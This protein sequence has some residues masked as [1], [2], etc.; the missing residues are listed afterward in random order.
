MALVP[1]KITAL[2][3]SDADGTD[4]KNIVS[5]AVVIIYD[6]DGNAVTLYDDA[7]GTNP[8][9]S[10]TTDSS[11]QVV[12]WLTQ[13]EYE[14]EVNGSTRRSITVSGPSPSNLDT[15]ANL[16]LLNPT[17]DGQIFICRERGNA[18]YVLQSSGYTALDGDVTFANGRIAA[19]QNDDGDPVKMGAAA[20]GSTDD[21][22]IINQC[23][24]RFGFANI[25]SNSFGI[26]Q[27]ILDADNQSIFGDS[28]ASAT[29]NIVT[30]N[31]Q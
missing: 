14:E 28:S 29:L 22:T 30:D 16:E 15:F 4:G 31:G 11:G 18:E 2:A 3:E 19:L 17:L 24:Q 12:V 7:D 25:K 9:T 5:G 10:K 26:S 6:R 20:D 27:L 23:I 1:H 8:S 21:S 13:G